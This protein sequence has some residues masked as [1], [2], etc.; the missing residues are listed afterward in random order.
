M[1]PL[2]PVMAMR[3]RRYGTAR[4]GGT[5]PG[6]PM[7]DEFKR[8]LLRGNVVDL[9][10]A[11][12]VGAAFTGVISSVVNDIINPIIGLVGGQ[13]FST[14]V[15]TLKENAEPEADVALRYGALITAIVNF[16]LVAA[17][18]FLLIVKPLNVL[19]ER[20]R[21]G[22]EPV[23]DTPAP[24]DEAVLLTEIR[25]LLQQRVS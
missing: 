3:M 18:I 11:V 23:E 12:V 5:I 24:S 14:L 21:R 15:I 7:L 22:E 13:D 4:R 16:V 25:D 2:D 8:F 17:A 20:R 1:N 9:A 19:A 6:G 10:V